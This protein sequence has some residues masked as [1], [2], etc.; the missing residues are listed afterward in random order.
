VD[1]S[2]IEGAIADALGW[3][4]MDTS[5]Y[6]RQLESPPAWIHIDNQA[7][8][9]TDW[10]QTEGGNANDEDDSDLMSESSSDESAM[11]R[12]E[13][14][15]ASDCSI[16][17]SFDESSLNGSDANSF[18][19]LNNP[20]TDQPRV[21]VAG[22]EAIGT[23]QR[24]ANRSEGYRCGCELP[25]G[26]SGLCPFNS[27]QAARREVLEGVV[28]QP[29]PLVPDVQRLIQLRAA[30]NALRQE[31]DGKYENCGVCG[32]VTRP[33]GAVCP[34]K[35]CPLCGRRRRDHNN[36]TFCRNQSK[37]SSQKDT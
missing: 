21:Q 5:A 16:A 6:S 31:Q 34:F 24:P 35:P 19:A 10:I 17:D 20:R 9:T 27:T 37:K 13:P 15:V 22:D 11:E 4:R 2:I 28:V 33:H 7:T 8:R 14:S 36:N 1:P 25:L 12:S 3:I 29:M 26:H 18:R 23:L 30:G 32:R